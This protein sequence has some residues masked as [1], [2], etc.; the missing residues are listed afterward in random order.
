MDKLK[1]VLHYHE[2]TKH[3]FQRFAQGPDVL[4]WKNQPNPFRYYSGCPRVALPFI[5]DELPT[6]YND[7]YTPKPAFVAPLNLATLSHFFR[8]SFGLSAWKRYGGER[9]ALR[10]NP[11]SGNLHPTEAYLVVVGLADLVDGT[12][13]YLS[14][15]HAFERR[16]SA[17]DGVADTRALPARAFLVGLSSVHWREAWKYG[18]RAY[19]YCQH[20]VGHAVAAIRYAAACFGWRATL[21]TAW[22]DADIESLLGLDRAIDCG[23]AEREYPE[24]MVMVTAVSEFSSVPQ[25][26]TL[27]AEVR[28][29]D[30]CWR[31]RAN[32]LSYEHRN[33]WPLL[34]EVAIATK[35]SITA[36]STQTY[37]TQSPLRLSLCRDA[38]ASIILKRRSAQVFDQTTSISLPVFYRMLDVLLPR[39]DV[40]PWDVMDWNA[41]VHLVIFVHRVE[42]LIP[43]LY[44]LLRH[45]NIEV[46]MRAELSADFTWSLVEGAPQHLL[47][48]QLLAGDSQNAARTLCCRQDIAADG[49]F[50]IAMLAEYSV[51]LEQKPWVYRQLFWEAG[52][53]GQ[54]LYLEAEAAGVR[55]TGI[56]C[57]FDDEVHTLFGLKSAGFQSVYHFTVGMPIEDTRLETEP[58]YAHVGQR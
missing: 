8:L 29:H 17:P 20:D 12:Y 3:R 18:E 22:A 19:R 10:C 52:M 26:E 35:K 4:D 44:I 7:L 32:V 57:Y 56:G 31:G 5:E 9:W 24:V 33:V 54:A 47:F 23:V 27:L 34:D 14:Y 11:S 40:A 53:L 58:P 50:S 30:E 45:P 25:W 36:V 46:R 42:H 41:R 48:F 13:H 16:W 49:A 21:L 51:S 1:Q 43:G 6:G 15:D 28:C 38:A 39:A 2:S 55:G 37:P